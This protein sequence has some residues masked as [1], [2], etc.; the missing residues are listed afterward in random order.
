[1]SYL[2]P[3]RKHRDFR[4]ASFSHSHSIS[5]STFLTRRLPTCLAF[6]VYAS[7]SLTGAAAHLDNPFKSVDTSGE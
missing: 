3:G 6:M 5:T 7:I 1:M 2:G 4:D